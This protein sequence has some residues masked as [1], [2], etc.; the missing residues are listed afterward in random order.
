MAARKI[1]PP[2]SVPRPLEDARIFAVE[3]RWQIGTIGDSKGAYAARRS[4]FV[5]RAPK[6]VFSP[7]IGHRTISLSRTESACCREKR[8]HLL[9]KG[10][11]S[12]TSDGQMGARSHRSRSGRSRTGCLSP[13][14]MGEKVQVLCFS[15]AYQLVKTA[16]VSSPRK[17][18]RSPKRTSDFPRRQSVN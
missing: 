5:A 13:P 15:R 7:E 16:P 12:P 18:S 9:L 14:C 2:R 10:G 4:L 8:Q 3:V 1:A 11:R 17:S 6:A